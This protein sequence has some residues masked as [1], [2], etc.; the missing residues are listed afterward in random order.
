MDSQ[1]IEDNT[2]FYIEFDYYERL[3]NGRLCPK[4]GG[5]T[6][7]AEE[8]EDNTR[9]SYP[10]H[11]FWELFV[12][13]AVLGFNKKKPLP[14][15]KPHSSFRWMNIGNIHQKNLLI[16]SVSNA[17]SFEILKNKE[18]LRKIIEEHANAGLAQIDKELKNN[19]SAYSD[20]E[21]LTFKVLN[22]FV[23]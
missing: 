11:F 8:S 2:A 22:D 23:N 3:F 12:Y 18:N 17:G 16:L 7:R 19:P 14:L 1:I 20:E 21:A 9:K 10:F 5:D 13:A 4:R 15:K 6:S